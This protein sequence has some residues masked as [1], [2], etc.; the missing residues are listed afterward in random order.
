MATLA[1]ATSAGTRASPTESAISETMSAATVIAVVTASPGM[2]IMAA[3]RRHGLSQRELAG[4]LCASTGMA[5]VSRHEVSRWERGTRL[6]S[7]YWLGPL[8]VLLEIDPADLD[9]AVVQAR[10]NRLRSHADLLPQWR[11]TRAACTPSTWRVDG[12]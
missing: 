11:V 4:R 8:A 5:T 6:P 12:S 2:M 7:A 9:R 1:T 3:R 10:R